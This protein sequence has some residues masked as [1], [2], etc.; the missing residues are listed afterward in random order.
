MIPHAIK[1]AKG[2]LYVDCEGWELN[3]RELQFYC[4]PWKNQKHK[5]SSHTPSHKEEDQLLSSTP[6]VPAVCML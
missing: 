1:V 3:R 2:Y 5:L 6:P 4:L